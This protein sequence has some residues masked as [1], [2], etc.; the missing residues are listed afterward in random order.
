M[1]LRREGLIRALASA[2]Y[3]A[4]LSRPVSLAAGYARRAPAYL[5]LVYHRVNDEGDPFLPSVPTGVFDAHMAFVARTY[6]VLPVEQLAERAGRGVLPRNALAITFDDGY[7]DNLTHAAPVLARYGLPATIFLATGFIGTGEVPWFDRLAMALKT[8]V[9]PEVV[10]PWGDRLALSDWP[11]RLRALQ[12]MLSYLKRLADDERQRGLDA[13]LEQLGGPDRRAT[14]DL[15]LTWDDVHALGGLGFSIGAHTVNHPILSRVPVER[16]WTE[17]Q[18]SRT[19][20]QG[21]CGRLPAVFAYPNGGPEDYTE[22]V[23]HLVR[24]AGFAC[25]VT[26]RFGVNTARTSPWELRRGGPWEHHLPTFAL[27][28]ARYRLL[29]G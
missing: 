21:A 23:K 18:G 7:R 26:T 17:I 10:A 15:M 8:A 6:R 16:A 5:V 22:I 4:G 20:I 9:V 3:H 29:S 1:A 24:E 27:K 28:L 2:W 19:M 14:K 25:A 13:V 11:A 12:G